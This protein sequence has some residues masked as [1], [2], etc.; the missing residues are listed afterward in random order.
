MLYILKSKK[1]IKILFGNIIMLFFSY[2][3]KENNNYD[4]T[5]KISN[6]MRQIKLFFMMLLGLLV[7]NVAM[8][9]DTPIPASQLPAAAKTFVK[10]HF[11]GKKITSAEKDATS[12]ECRLDDGTEIEF[13]RRGVWDKVDCK[14]RQAVPA[15]IVPKSIQ[16]YVKSNYAD[17]TIKKID[18]ERYGYEIELSN[19]VELKFNKKGAFISVGD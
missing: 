19:D 16:Q 13:N 5:P 6:T 17:C 2:L 7:A 9:D 12:Y 4:I 18:K 8:A 11:N 15:T 10:K 14:S 1:N 3:C